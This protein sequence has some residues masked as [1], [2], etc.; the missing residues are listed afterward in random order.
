MEGNSLHLLFLLLAAWNADVMHGLQ[1][2]S[3]TMRLYA[4]DGEMQRRK[5]S[6]GATTPTLS[7]LF[8]DYFYVKGRDILSS[9]KPLLF[10]G[11]R[12]R[13]FCYVS[14]TDT[15]TILPFCSRWAIA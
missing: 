14:E 4:M 5:V 7:H 9:F 13:E 10:A 12:Q 2:P 15:V 3:W 8:L 1:Q 6:C 11:S